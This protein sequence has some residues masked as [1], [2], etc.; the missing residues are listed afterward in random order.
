MEL[1][2][3]VLI[4]AFTSQL[5]LIGLLR[6]QVLQLK[7]RC[8]WLEEQ[9]YKQR[10]ITDHNIEGLWV[11]IQMLRHRI[12]PPVRHDVDDGFDAIPF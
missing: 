8:T 6:A 3:Y 10:A 1:F 11:D 5:V 12:D 4:A 7:R 2:A 9:H